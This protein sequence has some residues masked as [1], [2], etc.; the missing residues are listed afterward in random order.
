MDFIEEAATK[1]SMSGRPY[2]MR[3]AG[4]A[5]VTTNQWLREALE[6]YRRCTPTPN[7]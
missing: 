6:R 4:G 7:P 3:C 2:L 1:S 5:P